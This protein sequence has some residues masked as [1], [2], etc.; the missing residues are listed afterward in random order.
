MEDADLYSKIEGLIVGWSNDGTKTAG[1]LTRQIM[2]LLSCEN[3]QRITDKCAGTCW[4]LELHGKCDDA[5]IAEKQ[6]KTE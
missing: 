1:V 6:I 2:K 3:E 4:F 5:C